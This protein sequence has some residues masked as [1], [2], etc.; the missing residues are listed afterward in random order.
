M[1]SLRSLLLNELAEELANPFSDL[2][3]QHFG[4]GLLSDDIQPRR[5]RNPYTALSLPVAAGY[6]RP[7]RIAPAQQSGV[8]NI[9][10]D[11]A[12]FKVNLDVQQFQP[13][14][15][16]VKV[17]E[18]YLVVEAKHEERQDKHG[19]ISRSFTRRYKLPQDVNQ[20]A[21]VSSLSSDGVLTISATVKNQLPSGERQIPITQTNQP[22]LKKSKP[23]AALENGT[24]GKGGKGDK[25]ES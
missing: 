11:K 1:A 4:I 9:H 17:V 12:A 14:E 16:S 20:D 6:I 25:M 13:E 23:D 19:Y 8:S 21:I 24:G 22:A 5:C 15:V 10:H 7:W 2:T 18:G 3:D